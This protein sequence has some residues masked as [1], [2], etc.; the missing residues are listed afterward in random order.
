MGKGFVKF[1]DGTHGFGFIKN[2]ETGKDIFFHHTG[3]LD[4]VVSAD[5]VEYEEAV[6]KRGILAVDIKKVRNGKR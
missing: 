5:Y 3:T 6:G 2:E 4:K 1:F